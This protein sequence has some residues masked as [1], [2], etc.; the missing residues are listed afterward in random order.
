MSQDFPIP[1]LSGEE[2]IVGVHASG[3]ELQ[4][5]MNISLARNYCANCKRKIHCYVKVDRETREATIHNTCKNQECECKCKTH[6]ACKQCGYLH[7]YGQKCNRIEPERITNPEEDAAFERIMKE[8]QEL[9]EKSKTEQ[10]TRC[11]EDGD[12]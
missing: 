9:R 2:E 8:W 6:Y 10:V 5:G 7:P 1:S 3:I 12:V 11:Q 4:E